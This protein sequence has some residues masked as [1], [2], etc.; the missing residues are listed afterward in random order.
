M[1]TIDYIARTFDDGTLGTNFGSDGQY[2]T[3]LEITSAFCSGA[4]TMTRSRALASPRESPR[5]VVGEHTCRVNRHFFVLHGKLRPYHSEII[6][7][8]PSF[9]YYATFCL[10][11]TS[12]TPPWL[13]PHFDICTYIGANNECKTT[14]FSISRAINQGCDSRHR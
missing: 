1:V 8:R 7:V 4:D 9:P 11:C 10:S 6:K 12:F 14:Y 13:F 2:S 3:T 5:G